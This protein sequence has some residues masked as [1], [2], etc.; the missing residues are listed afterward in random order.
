MEQ[1]PDRFFFGLILEMVPMNQ[2]VNSMEKETT[3]SNQERKML[4]G[5]A[6]GKLYKEIASEHDISV[7]TV[8][9]HLKNAYRK[10]NVASRNEAAHRYNQILTP[11]LAKA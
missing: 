6:E 4:K 11:E 2:S 3:L 8:K 9:K 5:L 1:I 7:N 10:L